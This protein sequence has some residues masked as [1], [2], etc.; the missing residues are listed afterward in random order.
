M[1]LRV[2]F[3]A[4]LFGAAAVLPAWS[5]IPRTLSYQ[6][7]LTDSLGVPKPDGTYSITFRLYDGASGGTALWTEQKT[8]QVKRGL[9]STILGDQVVFGSSLT[10][11]TQYWLS[12]QV[13]SE[14][15]L[16][17]RV[18]LT[19]VANSLR[20]VRADTASY[21]MAAPAQAFV[22][23]ARV[24]GTVPNNSITGA[25]VAD[26]SLTAA[27]IATN[28]IVTS[29]NGVRDDVAVVSGRGIAVSTYDD[30][31]R[32]GLDLTQNW[33]VSSLRSLLSVHNTWTSADSPV[34]LSRAASSFA[35]AGAFVKGTGSLTQ[36]NSTIQLE[37]FTNTGEGVWLRNASASNTTPVIKLH[38]HPSSTASFVDGM[39]WDGVSSAT[40]KFHITSAGT[41]VAGSD[42]AEAFEA[43]GGK[44]NVEPGDVLVLSAQSAHAVEKCSRPYDRKLVGVYSTRPGVLGAEKDG[45]TRIAENDIPVAITGIVPTKVSAE[46]G[47]I[48]VGDLLTTSSRPGYAMKAS[49]RVVDGMEVY[50]TGTILGKALEKMDS[51]EGL[52]KVLI[53]NR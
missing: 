18:P 53:M 31:V 35:P 40:R 45:E 44:H 33:T 21:A 37:N 22:D 19:P 5:Q 17:P 10:F 50:P 25:K 42:F 20:S 4:I 29:V 27:D 26:G 15:E 14:P 34:V 41:Y 16:S 2:V 38:Q 7:V 32:I 11:S 43:V 6:G 47:A 39:A 9:F 52:I 13:A 24:A 12:I 28:Q 46:N 36:T 48:H 49:P 3:V 23:S 30:S 1:K 51:G 8:L